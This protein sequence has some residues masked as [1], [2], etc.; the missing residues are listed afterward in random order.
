MNWRFGSVLCT[1]YYLSNVF[2]ALGCSF[3]FA[4]DVLSRRNEGMEFFVSDS[5][6][7]SFKSKPNNLSDK[8]YFISSRP[9][10]VH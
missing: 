7:V 4:S 5:S 9:S 2:I 3:F 8:Y 10:I 1:D 6:L